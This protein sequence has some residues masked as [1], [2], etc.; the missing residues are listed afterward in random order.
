MIR[1]HSTPERVGIEH[2]EAERNVKAG[3][4]ETPEEGVGIWRGVR[5]A[6]LKHRGDPKPEAPDRTVPKR[7]RRCEGVILTVGY[8]VDEFIAIRRPTRR[9]STVLMDGK[10]RCREVV[11][12]KDRG[13]RWRK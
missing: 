4:G 8:G 3:K 1:T 13:I 12:H 10:L 9:G 7:L 5:F 11:K 6:P 2:K